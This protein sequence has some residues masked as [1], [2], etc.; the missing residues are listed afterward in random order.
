MNLFSK[1]TLVVSA[2]LLAAACGGA[3]LTI[4]LV[5]QNSSGE[6]GTIQFFDKGTDT[7]LLITTAGATDTNDQPAFINTGL[8]SPVGAFSGSP[9]STLNPVHQDTSDTT[10]SGRKLTDL[11]GGKYH[12]DI[13]SSANPELVNSCANIP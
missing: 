10:V 8:C 1:L 7:E 11:T 12:V 6:T 5:T 13:Q 9:L 3:G 2:A 4:D